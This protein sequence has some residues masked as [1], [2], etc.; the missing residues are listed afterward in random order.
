MQRLLKPTSS[1]ITAPSP[2]G[3][4]ATSAAFFWHAIFASAV[5]SPAD[6]RPA[7]PMRL[8]RRACA[9]T[10]MNAAGFA[11]A[12]CVLRRRISSVPPISPPDHQDARA[13]GRRGNGCGRCKVEPLSRIAPIPTRALAKPGCSSAKPPRYV[14]ACPGGSRSDPPCRALADVHV[15]VPILP[16]PPWPSDVNTSLLLSTRAVLLSRRR[17]PRQTDSGPWMIL[18]PLR[19]FHLVQ[20]RCFPCPSTGDPTP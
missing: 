14:S 1:R 6:G 9:G 19:T 13:S 20:H 16:P 18:S 8:R 2:P 17:S 10:A 3:S 5:S 7:C 4:F 15:A 12:I 11:R